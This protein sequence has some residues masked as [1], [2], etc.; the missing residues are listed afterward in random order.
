M[1]RCTVYACMSSQPCLPWFRLTAVSA[2]RQRTFQASRPLALVIPPPPRLPRLP[3]TGAVQIPTYGTHHS[4]MII[5][6]F[7]TGVRVVVLTANFLTVDVTDKSQAVWYQDFRRR[8]S[9]ACDFEVCYSG[10][11]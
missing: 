2:T 10:F 8:E 11:L 1:F 7:P 9:G 3:S 6:K 4:K 5:L